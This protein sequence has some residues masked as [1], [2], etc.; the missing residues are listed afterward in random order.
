MRAAWQRSLATGEPYEAEVRMR[1]HDGVWRW[2]LSRA[3]ALR[4]EATGDI[5]EWIAGSVDIDELRNAQQALQ[6]A[7]RRKDEFL[8]TLAHELRNP[9]APLR[10][11]VH[12]LQ[13]THA[14][15]T[16]GRVHAM[17]QRQIDHMVRLVDD[18]LEVSRITGGKIDLRRA[19]VQLA[20]VLRG[21]VETSRP[22]IEAAD[23]RLE[24]H[25]GEESML[26]DADAV[27]LAQVFANLL[28]NAA[29]YTDAGGRIE[30]AARREND[31]ALVTVRD[32]GIGIAADMLP[33]VFDLFT[34]IDRDR[35]RSQGGLGIGL[36][37]VKS[38]VGMHGGS[39][40]AAS[41]G[42]GHGAEFTV[43]L[44]L[45]PAGLQ[46]EAA[47]ADS[48][49]ATPSAQRVLVVDDNVD[50]ADSLGVLLE[51]MGASVKVVHDGPAALAAVQTH[52]PGVVLLDIGMPGMDGYEVARRCARCPVATRSSWW[53]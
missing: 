32:T 10:N 29:K 28:N 19:P 11:A 13:I 42:P 12:I 53:R 21:A 41:A 16:A 25:I 14:P 36:S 38:L 23:L 20:E 44:P 31:Q 3:V 33:R 27:R 47:N 43:R 18:L 15:E 35:G 48:A 34:Q 8:A 37:L 30:L 52:R 4:N 45:A 9:L 26:L 1:R 51:F 7:D 50:A 22:L 49:A 6:A 40:E 17:M 2:T 5:T 46:A 24:Q 39:V